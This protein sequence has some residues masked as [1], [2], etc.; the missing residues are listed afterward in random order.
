M[1][2]ATAALQYNERRGPRLPNGRG[3]KMNRFLLERAKTTPADW[4]MAGEMEMTF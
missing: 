1:Q 2:T 4:A 3:T